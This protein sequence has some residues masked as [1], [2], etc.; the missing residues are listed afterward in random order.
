LSYVELLGPHH[1]RAAFDCGKEALNRFLRQQA[2]QN[3]DRHLG[4]TQV[5]VK[6]PGEAQIQGY[7]TLVTRTVEAETVPAASKKLPRGPIGVILLGRL[8]V[9]SQFHGQGLGKRMLLRAMAEVE[10]TSRTVGV[11]ALVLDVIDEEAKAWYLGLD[12]GFQVFPSDP[13][14]LFVPV[15]FLRQLDFG[16]IGNEL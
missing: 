6:A 12:F 10:R 11:F 9:D 14:R 3:A 13:A 5:V 1:D 8:A 4:V 7:F 2:R 15:A 16:P